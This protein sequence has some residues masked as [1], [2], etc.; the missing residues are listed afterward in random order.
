MAI[1]DDRIS[2]RLTGRPDEDGHTLLDD[3]LKQISFFLQALNKTFHYVNG[4]EEDALRYQV[5]DLRHSSPAILTLRTESDTVAP[6][7]PATLATF[8]QSIAAIQVAGNV[9]EDYDRSLLE[10]YKNLGIQLIRNRFDDVAIIY[11]DSELHIGPALVHNINHVLN[12]EDLEEEGSIS[13]RL[14]EI[15]IHAGTN[16]FRLYPPIGANKVVCHFAVELMDRAIEAVNRHVMVYGLLKFKPRERFSEEMTVRDLEVYPN[17]D[18]LP[19]IEDLRGMAPNATGEL[20]SEDFIR[21][22]RLEW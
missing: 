11:Q 20:T 7:G 18:D 22:L 21:K 4:D 5:V 6:L 16:T 1:H 2:I 19:N 15:N 12:Q 10:S 13:G 8:Y 17:D 9:R 14:E 3:F